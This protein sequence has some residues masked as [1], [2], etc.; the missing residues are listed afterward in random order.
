MEFLQKFF[1][2]E[3]VAQTSLNMAWISE[4]H[5]M[6]DISAIE[7]STQ[8]IIDYFKSN[9]YKNDHNLE[10]LF[11]IDEKTHSIVE[12]ITSH[13]INIEIINKEIALRI[14]DVVFL[15]HRQLFLTYL[16]LTENHAELH[17]PLLHILLA[18]AMRNATQMI[19]WRYY[20]YLTA[21][22]NVWLQLS[23]LYKIAEQ[24]M[25]LNAKIQAYADQEPVSLSTAYIHACMLGSLESISLKCQQIEL[26]SRILMAWSAKISIDN[27]YDP[28]HHLFYVDTASNVPARRI[29]NFKPSSTYRYWDFSSV[30]SKI[31]LCMSLIE[32]KVEPKQP[33]L[34]DIISS[35]HAPATFEILGT[36]WSLTDYKRQRRAEERQKSSVSVNATFGFQDICRE[37]WAYERSKTLQ[38]ERFQQSNQSFEERPASQSVNKNM[39]SIMYISA[40][41]TNSTIVDQSSRGLGL[42]VIKLAHEVSLGMLVGITA[43]EQKFCSRFGLVRSVRPLANNQLHI[44]IELLSNL[45]F[46]VTL[47]NVSQSARS[48]NNNVLTSKNPLPQTVFGNTGDFIDSSFGQDTHKFCG[49]HLPQEHSLATQETLLIPKLQYNKNDIFKVTI[50]GEDMFIKFTKS[51][52]NHGSWARVT[53]TTKINSHQKTAAA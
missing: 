3:P 42:H 40:S 35:K 29:R 52:E 50:L 1:N 2:R 41:T 45:G 10:T 31:D 19:K 33:L 4:L 5:G 36:E 15:Y 46:L 51:Y 39:D 37:L 17:Q 9:A 38:G 22:A 24:H 8:K 11:S 44:G 21:P 32:Y 20:N 13:F 27:S 48:A 43:K 34:K 7:F 49:I 28:E 53:F 25:L 30:N 12:R 47:E 16:A 18:R 14:S 26:T 6:D 23:Q